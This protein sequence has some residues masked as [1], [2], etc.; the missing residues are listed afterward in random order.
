MSNKMR[1][2]RAIDESTC[3]A[4]LLKVLV[5]IASFYIKC[6]I[7]SS[8]FISAYCGIFS[9]LKSVHNTVNPRRLCRIRTKIPY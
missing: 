5:L 4:L 8:I 7:S 6:I 3:N 2:E 9:C 1:I